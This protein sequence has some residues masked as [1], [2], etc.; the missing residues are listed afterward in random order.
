[1][2]KAARISPDAADKFQLNAGILV[3]G[4]DVTKPTEP[5]V[6]NIVCETTGDLSIS[7]VPTIEDLFSDVNNAPL[8][9]VEGINVTGWNCTLGFTALSVTLSTIELALGISD[10][11]GTGT[12]AYVPSTSRERI[13]PRDLYWL[14]DTGDENELLCVKIVNA[15]SRSGLSLT[16]TNKGKGKLGIT[17]TGHVSLDNPDAAPMEFYMLTKQANTTT[18]SNDD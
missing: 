13:Y 16:T 8:N 12:V 14:G 2:W 7:C 9:T 18:T 11:V 5:D 3:S 10:Y 6:T 1:M 4:F 17:L 15:L